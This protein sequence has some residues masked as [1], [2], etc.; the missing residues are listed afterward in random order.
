MADVPV[1]SSLADSA[2]FYWESLDTPQRCL[3]R[4]GLA[5]RSWS[6]GTACSG[7][8]SVVMVLEH[9]GRSCGWEFTHTFSCESHPEKQAWARENFPHVPLIFPDI[10]QLHTGR[11]VNVVTGLEADVPAVDIFIAGFVCKSVSSEN[12]QRGTH[13]ACIAA[14]TGKTGSTFEGLRRFVEKVRPKIV[15]C[16]NVVGLLKRTC[17]GHP[18]I[19][20]VAEAFLLLG[21]HFAYRHV[22]AKMYL[23]PQRRHRVW[24]WAIRKDI[25]AAPAASRVNEI[26][27]QLEQPEPA[28]LG[29]FLRAT[30]GGHRPRQELN[31]REAEAV[32]DVLRSRSVLRLDKAALEGLVI[33]IS[34]S[35]GRTPW[36]AGATPCVLP[37]SRLYV[38]HVQ[39][40]LGP[41]EAAALQGLWPADFRALSAWCEDKHRSRVVADMAG[42][43]FT[44]TVC[45]AVCFAVFLSISG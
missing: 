5:G 34:K 1:V 3:L 31:A 10:C 18:Q 16:E 27:E 39:C 28:P 22:D 29:A 26:L 8:D 9:I 38:R 21:Y 41:R 4:R 40:V 30:A 45:M 20:D 23:L 24:M 37:N 42:N 43:A 17:G 19:V 25:S 44:S 15:I 6:L 13:G 33:D 12:N 2:A 32:T 11:C 7:S 35:A 36:C 14:G